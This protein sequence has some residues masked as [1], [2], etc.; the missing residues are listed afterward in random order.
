MKKK[1]E[2]KEEATTIYT[3]SD[4]SSTPIQQTKSNDMQIRILL[5]ECNEFKVLFYLACLNVIFILLLFSLCFVS[6]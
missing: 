2:K 3:E 6:L 4:P 5:S 1:N